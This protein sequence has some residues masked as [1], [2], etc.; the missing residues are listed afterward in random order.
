MPRFRVLC[1]EAGKWDGAEHRDVEAQDEHQAAEQVC[2]GP[3][4]EVGKPGQLRAQAAPEGKPGAQK[5]LYV[6]N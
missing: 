6:R 5:M 1:Y 2:G 4:V 3:L